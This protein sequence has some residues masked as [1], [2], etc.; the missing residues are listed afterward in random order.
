MNVRT[1]VAA[2]CAVIAI[3]DYV[4]AREPE[5]EAGA[6]LGTERGAPQFDRPIPNIHG[7][8]LAVM[9]VDYP[10]GCASSPSMHTKSGFIYGFVLSGEIEARVNE[11]EARI[12]RTGESW[13][14]PP[15]APRSINRN[16]SETSPAKLLAVF[17]VDPDD[18]A[19]GIRQVDQEM[20]AVLA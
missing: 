17:V 9:E 10:P 4:S 13:S 5:A 11:G 14:A 19:D 6:G 1:I 12:Y 8:S 15:T 7:K 20:M 3:P 18:T 2:T 16:A